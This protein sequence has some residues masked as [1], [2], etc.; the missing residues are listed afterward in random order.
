MGTLRVTLAQWHTFNAVVEHGGFAAAAQH[1][2]RSQSSVSYAVHKLQQQLGVALLHQDGRKAQLTET[3]RLLLERARHLLAD[4]ARLEDFATSLES[5]W[6]AEIT[7][8]VDAAF[9]TERV[10]QALARF[11]TEAQTT[12][13][14]LHEEV[15]SGV[16]D[17]LQNGSADLGISYQV[18]S[19]LLG[20]LL[21]EVEFVAVAHPAHPLHRLDRPLSPQDLIRE[22]QVVIRD[23][24]VRQPDSIGWLDT[25][26]RWTLSS[27]DAAIA[28]ITGGMGFG[29]LPRHRIQAD[30]D[31]GHLQPLDMGD[32]ATYRVPLYLVM[33]RSETAGPASRRLKTLLQ[34]VVAPPP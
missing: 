4:A 18:P 8:V 19:G 24:G 32:G 31:N 11:T 12:R 5:G 25:E 9:P 30:L 22:L 20:D 7:L 34:Q 33:A 17:A 15:M 1:L 13:V 10:M 28:A 26:Y 27:M 14:Q 21:L 2:H 16:T 3:G 6:E 29:W 23:S